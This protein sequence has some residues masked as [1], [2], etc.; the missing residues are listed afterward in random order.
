MQCC[1]GLVPNVVSYGEA[2]SACED[3]VRLEKVDSFAVQNPAFNPGFEAHNGDR[4]SDWLWNDDP[5]ERTFVDDAVFRSGAKS[6][7]FTAGGRAA[8]TSGK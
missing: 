7:K 1:M 4:A 2:C 8:T 5:G 3:G 6:M